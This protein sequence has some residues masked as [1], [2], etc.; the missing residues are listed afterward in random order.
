MNFMRVGGV[1][2][3]FKAAAEA[4]YA[5]LKT[6]KDLETTALKD[7]VAAA[8]AAG[9][10]AAES[11]L[12]W[13]KAKVANNPYTWM[14]FK[15][16][17]TIVTT[18]ICPA[19]TIAVGVT[20]LV[21][22]SFVALKNLKEASD[23][24]PPDLTDEAKAACMGVQTFQTLLVITTGV[25][26]IFVPF[27]NQDIASATANGVSKVFAAVDFSAIL[28]TGAATTEAAKGTLTFMGKVVKD[29][30]AGATGQA[31][32]D[33]VNKMI[34]KIKDKKD[35]DG[36]PAKMAMLT[37]SKIEKLKAE[38]VGGTNSDALEDGR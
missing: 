22:D 34:Q 35:K 3:T 26:N 16:V 37:C 27:A 25:V 12:V 15:V 5:S 31:T 10:A 29:A 23:D 21:V 7:K 8:G 28:E 13:A 38:A 6:L 2:A 30:F 9:K 11:G 24:L 32:D 4:K 17:S 20:F 19:C 33:G 36:D 14:A 18:I 1:Y